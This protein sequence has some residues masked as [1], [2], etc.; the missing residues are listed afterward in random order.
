MPRVAE[1]TNVVNP[2]GDHSRSRRL[3]KIGAWIG[4]AVAIF[5]LLDL[6]GVDIGAWIGGMWD[7]LQTVS[8]KYLIAAVALQ[9]LQTTLTAAA[10]LQILRAG[11]PHAEIPFA[12][13]LAAYAVGTGLNGVLPANVGL[14]VTLFMF[15]AVI[16][17]ATFSGVLAGLLV[18]KIFF[19]VVG[20]FVY[21]YLFLSAPGS[22]T[23]ELGGLRK[24]PGLVALIVAGAALLIVLVGRAF[25]TKLRSEWRK[26]K[27]GG[28]I[29]A[30]PRAYL[31]RVVLPS[32]AGYGAKLA[33]TAVFLA[34][35]AIPVTF[36]SVMHVIGG[37]S[38][39]GATAATPGG[40]GVNEAVSVVALAHYADA[41]T[42]TAFSVAQHLVGTSWSILFALILVT[43][44]FGWTNGRALLKSAYA[45]ARHRGE[46]AAA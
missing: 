5:A 45:D 6:L 25:M 8:A 18:E 36:G 13:V 40:A 29:L 10:W 7:S 23:L 12:P 46:K 22:F 43:T 17:N 34:A 3:I 31:L 30:S 11:Y 1:V 14:F 32:L 24:H 37:N 2:I 38:V 16:P 9:T 26:A 39:A 20:A 33:G 21:V 15:V 19:T 4:V 42:A 41:Q 35:F 28:A 44:V 27:Q